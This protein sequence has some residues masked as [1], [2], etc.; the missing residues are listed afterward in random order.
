MTKR[1]ESP[2]MTRQWTCPRQVGFVDRFVENTLIIQIADIVPGTVLTVGRIA[3]ALGDT[4]DADAIRLGIT[5]WTYNSI[6]PGDATEGALKPD[7]TVESPLAGQPLMNIDAAISGFSFDGAPS[8]FTLD[9]PDG[10][11]QDF[12]FDGIFRSPIDVLS[13]PGTNCIYLESDD[14][15]FLLQD[16]WSAARE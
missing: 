6:A 14:P 10:L 2:V 3:A 1:R 15:A 4:V 5:A 11:A 8:E 13:G 9:A 7:G 12:R 16:L